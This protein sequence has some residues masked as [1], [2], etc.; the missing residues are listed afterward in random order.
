MYPID[1]EKDVAYLGEMIGVNPH[2]MEPV[3]REDKYFPRQIEA[4]E[5]LSLGTIRV[6]PNGVFEVLDP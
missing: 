6:F 1:R 3:G 5:P 4:E 2:T